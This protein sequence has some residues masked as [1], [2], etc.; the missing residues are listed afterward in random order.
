MLRARH[1]G[2]SH[3]MNDYFRYLFVARAACSVDLSTAYGRFNAKAISV[4]FGLMC[5]IAILWVLAF[6]ADFGLWCLGWIS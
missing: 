4:S 1:R 6:A 5:M 2:D 3:K